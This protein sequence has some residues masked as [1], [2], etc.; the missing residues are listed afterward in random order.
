MFEFAHKVSF[1]LGVMVACA[2]GL[3]GMERPES[4]TD[5]AYTNQSG[6]VGFYA[7]AI[8]NIDPKKWKSP[9]CPTK[10][11]QGEGAQEDKLSEVALPEN[12]SAAIFLLQ[13]LAA[14]ETENGHDYAFVCFQ[15]ISFVCSAQ[16]LRADMLHFAKCNPIRGP[17]A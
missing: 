12:G 2:H 9:V 14:A 16:F 11:E 6:V 17:A 7:R 10:L 5:A 8:R 1:A 13:L 3:C 15:K 4:S